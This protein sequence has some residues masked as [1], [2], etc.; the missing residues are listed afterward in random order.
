MQPL[1]WY[2]RHSL[3]SLLREVSLRR[4]LRT[5]VEFFNGHRPHQGV[6]NRIPERR[7]IEMP[8]DGTGA[9]TDG[10]LAVE[11]EQFLGGLLDSYSRKAAKS[12][13]DVTPRRETPG[14]PSPSA[15]SVARSE[16]LIVTPAPA[17]EVGSA[18]LHDPSSYRRSGPHPFRAA[19]MSY[20]ASRGCAAM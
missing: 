16:A 14:P 19:S 5:Y 10:D 3:I 17:S 2:S 12:A 13:P 6:A 1:S 20:W 4:A 11:C 9:M 8:R 7:A 15:P 18:P